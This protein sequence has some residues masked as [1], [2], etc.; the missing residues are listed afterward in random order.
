MAKG[1]YYAGM[2]SVSTIDPLLEVG[3]GIY[4][5]GRCHR[6]SA[7]SGMI[8]SGE[9]SRCNSN[10]IEINVAAAATEGGREVHEGSAAASYP[11]KKTIQGSENCFFGDCR[12]VRGRWMLGC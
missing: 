11:R 6:V 3:M 4:L 1:T 8:W 12:P 10:Q 9:E 7:I 2:A 5:G